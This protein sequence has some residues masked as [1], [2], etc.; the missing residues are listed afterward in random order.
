MSADYDYM[1]GSQDPQKSNAEDLNRLARFMV[2]GKNFPI[3]VVYEKSV[4]EKNLTVEV[5]TDSVPDL[6]PGL[7]AGYTYFGQF[8]DHDISFDS[9]SD[10]EVQSDLPF[11]LTKVRSTNQHS[12]TFDLETIYGPNPLNEAGEI[13]DK[14]SN[15]VSTS[16]HPFLKVGRTRESTTDKRELPFDLFRN[17]GDPTAVIAD[18]RSDGNLLLAQMHLL[19]LKL[20]N[21]VVVKLSSHCKSRDDL[22]ARSRVVAIRCYQHLILHDFLRALV[23]LRILEQIKK[24]GNCIFK[25]KDLESA[26][27]PYEF[28]SAAFRFGHSMIRNS[29]QLNRIQNAPIGRIQGQTGKAR[30][31]GTSAQRLAIEW[32]VDWRLFFYDENKKSRNLANRIDTRLA[33][34][35][36]PLVPGH[37][38]TDPRN[39]SLAALDLFR[40]FEKRLASG[41]DLAEE[42]RGYYSEVKILSPAA[43]QSVFTSDR[44]DIDPSSFSTLNDVFSTNTPLWF[45]LLAEAENRPVDETEGYARLGPLCSVIVCETIIGLLCL[46]PFSILATPFGESDDDRL[47]FGSGVAAAR[48]GFGDVLR[49]VQSANEEFQKYL[50]PEIKLPFDDLYPE[51]DQSK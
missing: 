11:D 50:Y 26:F 42:A 27:V 2:G 7:P 37:K 15:L 21:A 31:G 23:D 25:P 5:P 46:S 10:R 43:I 12:P 30:F 17:P 6:K 34:G 32:A 36:S 28:T 20:H 47:V 1:F 35:L 51:S 49:L 33:N 41:Q 14:M 19:F 13:S 45:Y 16:C 29:Y 39:F 48:F 3:P 8:I 38:F 24:S 40:G 4:T 18:S 44:I 22:F 9:R